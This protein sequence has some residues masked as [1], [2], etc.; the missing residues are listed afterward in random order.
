MKKRCFIEINTDFKL[1]N[2]PLTAGKYAMYAFPNEK[3]FE[4]RLSSD[5]RFWGVTEPDYAND[6]LS[7]Q[8][9]AG[10][11]ASTVEQ[12]TI[13]TVAKGNGIAVVFSW[14]DR[15]WEVLITAQ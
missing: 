15:V 13:E 6:V 14:S 3:G 11:T 10:T 4:I 1:D 2:K 12:F 8:A 7:M 5:L 9:D